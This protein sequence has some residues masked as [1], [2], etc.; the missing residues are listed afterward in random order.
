MRPGWQ[1][2]R[3]S[4]GVQGR[5]EVQGRRQRQRRVKWQTL[6]EKYL[7]LQDKRSW[8]KMEFQ[9]HV[10]TCRYTVSVQVQVHCTCI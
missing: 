1:V 4:I 3:C 6:L 5:Q 9:I 10:Q 2:D 8:V 7:Y